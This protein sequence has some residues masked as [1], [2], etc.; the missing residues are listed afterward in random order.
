MKPLKNYV[1]VTE[2]ARDKKTSAGGIILTTEVQDGSAPG[3]VLEVG[4]EVSDMTQGNS[5]ALD[6]AKGLPVI[7]DGVKCVLVSDE[8]IRGVY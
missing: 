1:L 2:V 5:V 8:F 7:V 3:L 4:P 6:W